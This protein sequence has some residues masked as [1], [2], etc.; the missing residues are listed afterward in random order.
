MRT[1]WLFGA[2]AACAHPAPA[3]RTAPRSVPAARTQASHAAHATA[4]ASLDPDTVLATIRSDYLGGVR[5]CYA[6][7]LKRSQAAARITVSFTVDA[8]GRAREGAANGN[9]PV[10]DACVTSLI[11]RWQFPRPRDPSA[12]R[13]VLQLEPE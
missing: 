10:L 13:L 3:T 6:H 1:F 12:F 7:V 8:A 2:L 4:V 11:A 9:A 5:R